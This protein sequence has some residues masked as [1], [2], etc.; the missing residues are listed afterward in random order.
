M[1][2][3]STLKCQA[4]A[5]HGR[6]TVFL[7]FLQ[8]L[9]KHASPFHRAL[10]IYEF[11]HGRGWFFE[12]QADLRWMQRL[13]DLPFVFDGV[14]K[15]WD[16]VW[17]SLQHCKSWKSLVKRACRKHVLQE[18]IARDVRHYHGL[19]TEELNNGGHVVWQG[20]EIF[21]ACCAGICLP[22]M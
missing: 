7:V 4:F 8:H 22:D 9:G 2:S 15:N 3:A 5:S 18:R 21:G 10:L 1:M 12:V 13:V 11:Q 14:I 16:E 20:E 6:D 17:T 19:I